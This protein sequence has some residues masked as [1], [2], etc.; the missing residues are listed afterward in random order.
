MKP[1]A[2]VLAVLLLATVSGLALL[3]NACKTAHHSWCTAKFSA[4][5]HDTSGR[6]LYVP[7]HESSQ[8]HKVNSPG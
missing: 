5:S 7:G 4:A 2:L 6:N 1:A 3:N 8:R